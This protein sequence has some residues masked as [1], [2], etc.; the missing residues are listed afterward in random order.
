M[1]KKLW[2]SLFFDNKINENIITSKDII[3]SKLSIDKLTY[4][5]NLT[6]DH[7]D[8]II[9][10]SLDWK[11]EI[12]KAL[13]F[14]ITIINDNTI[15]TG[16]LFKTELIFIGD[17]KFII[18]YHFLGCSNYSYKILNIFN[19]KNN[20]FNLLLSLVFIGTKII[21]ENIY[22]LSRLNTLTINNNKNQIIYSIYSLYDNIN[23]NEAV[24][25]LKTKINYEKI[26]YQDLIEL[27]FSFELSFKIL[28]FCNKNSEYLKDEII[29]VTNEIKKR[30]L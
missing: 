8:I 28:N 4:F 19:D 27:K 18:N 22:N 1:I 26:L 20:S 9:D 15:F 24:Y 30:L 25:F 16:S 2:N 5:N 29:N 7:I 10:K 21:N 17:K 12:N 3:S 23:I 11:I 14:I 6:K 13:K